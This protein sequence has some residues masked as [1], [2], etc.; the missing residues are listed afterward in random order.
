MNYYSAYDLVIE[1]TVDLP[2]LPSVDLDSDTADVSIRKGVVKPVP[3]Q[4]GGIEGIHIEAE[5]GVCRFTYDSIGS[6]RVENGER[7]IFDPVYDEITGVKVFREA[8]ENEML[9]LILHQ[10]GYLVLHASAVSVGGKAAIFLGPRGV[11]KSTTAAA[12]YKEGYSVFDDDLVGIHYKDNGPVVVPGVPELRLHDDA[13]EALNIGGG[14]KPMDGW[15]YDKQYVQLESIPDTSSIAALYFLQVGDKPELQVVTGQEKI[16]N[17]IP[18][19]YVRGLLDDT[20]STPNHFEKCSSIAENTSFRVLQRPEEIT[21][22][23]S[24]VSLVID[25]LR[26]N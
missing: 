22:L 16:L 8:L 4:K 14:T 3:E 26:V 11:G 23:Q 13:I 19:T 18:Q 7:I 17:L 21:E 12:F 24:V 25:D 1:S 15:G 10:R 6:F 2:E 9:G 5:P 20:E